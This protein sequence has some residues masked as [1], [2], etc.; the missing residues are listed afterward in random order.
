MIK[1]DRSTSIYDKGGFARICVEI[2][3]KKPLVPTYMVFG[4]ERPIVYEGL[5]LVCFKC[6]KYGHKKEACP[7]NQPQDPLPANDL[8]SKDSG[9]EG[10]GD[11]PP[12]EKPNEAV[13]AP[14][15]TIGDGA[16]GVSGGCLSEGSPFG[17]IRILRRDFRGS[18][19]LIDS[20]KGSNGVAKQGVDQGHDEVRQDTRRAKGKKEDTVVMAEDMRR[21]KGKKE[22]MVVM[23]EVNGGNNNLNGILKT[24]WVPVG[25]KRKS[26]TSRKV[27]GKENKNP[28]FGKSH[29]HV[30]V[31]P[32]SGIVQVNPFSSLQ[33]NV[34]LN[35]MKGIKPT[36]CSVDVSAVGL[37][38][39]S[40]SIPIIPLSGQLQSNQSSTSDALEDGGSCSIRVINATAQ[41]NS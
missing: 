25:S 26:A 30:Q 24:E 34:G 18:A 35:M 39:S 5:H 19:G 36:V 3:L 23:A 40:S 12:S 20:R 17:K 33:D 31:G 29:R 37:L 13:R 6:G 8:P 41:M 2:D 32:A 14:T 22:D 10:N 4:E 21:A 11:E 7:T 1:V 27:K 15:A 28:A 16:T 9:A 38:A